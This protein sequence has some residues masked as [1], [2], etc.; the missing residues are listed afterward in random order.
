MEPGW[1]EKIWLSL[2]G[3]ERCVQIASNHP[4]GAEIVSSLWDSERESVTMRDGENGRSRKG[5]EFCGRHPAVAAAAAA[6]SNRQCN[7]VQLARQ[8]DATKA[9][10]QEGG[11]THLN[12]GIQP[13]DSGK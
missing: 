13:K 1:L 8:G 9:E 11:S 5:W 12:C 2:V 3:V 7:A 10:Q 6:S 4:A